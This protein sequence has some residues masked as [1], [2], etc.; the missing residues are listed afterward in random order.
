MYDPPVPSLG[1][2]RPRL[3]DQVTMGLL[4]YLTSHALDEDYAQAA[5]RR[6]SAAGAGGAT[7]V[8][9]RKPIGLAGALALAVF[10]VLAVTAAAQTSQDSASQERERQ[11]LIDQVKARKEALAADRTTVA[12]LQAGNTRLRSALLRS[13]E[14]SS[15]L[16]R[17]VRLLALGSGTSAV[18]GPGVEITVDNP[19]NAPSSQ[20]DSSKVLDKD[21]QKLVN[22]L[23]AAGAEAITIN[24]QRLTALSAI[25]HAGSAITVNYTRLSPPYVI[26]A[27]G[28]PKR[29]PSRFAETTSGATWLDLQRQFGFRFRMLAQNSLQLPAASV[30]DLRLARSAGTSAGKG[31]S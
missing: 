3:P 15:G 14:T 22:G 20:N 31:L 11:A 8:R 9:S 12:Q 13:G 4:A 18:H 21:L 28:D 24:G 29:L 10:A 30:P 17:E 6:A 7:R 2:G 27:I 16:L 19:P 23:W 5:A 1:E 26:L 25:R